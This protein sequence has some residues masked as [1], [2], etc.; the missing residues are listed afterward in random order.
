MALWSVPATLIRGYSCQESLR[1]G[2]FGKDKCKVTDL[3]AQTM[4]AA[5]HQA[6]IVS[7]LMIENGYPL[8]TR[9][10]GRLAR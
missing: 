4:H 5:G 1:S 6:L 2:F 9:F 7:F 3:W 8:H 10:A